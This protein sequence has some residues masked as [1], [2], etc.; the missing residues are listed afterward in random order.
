MKRNEAKKLLLEG[1]K[2]GE[3]FDLIPGQDCL[4][5]KGEW[6]DKPEVSDEIIYIPDIGL[7]DLEDDDVPVSEK[8]GFLY[9]AKDFL[10]QTGGNV[11]AAKELFDFVDWQNPNVQDLMDCTDDDEAKEIYGQTWEEMF[12]SQ[13]KRRRN[14][15]IGFNESVTGLRG[16]RYFVLISNAVRIVS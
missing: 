14:E 11:P 9:T 7:N 10:N 4:I 1:K 3:I 2:I 6:P 13:T 12:D 16:F 15:G 5:Y 8:L